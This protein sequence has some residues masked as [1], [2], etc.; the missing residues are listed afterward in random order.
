MDFLRCK[1][2]AIFLVG[3]T[4]FY[5]S[6]LLAESQE[7]LPME[8]PVLFV[9]LGSHCQIPVML[10]EYH[11]SKRAFPFDWLLTC[12]HDDFIKV[13]YDDFHFFLNENFLLSHPKVPSQLINSYYKFEFR[14]EDYPLD[15]PFRAAKKL[16]I[17]LAKPK[18]DRRI[19]RFRQIRN[20]KGKVFFLRAAS[21]NEKEAYYA[22]KADRIITSKQAAELRD[23][24][25]FFFPEVD[26]TLIIVNYLKEKAPPIHQLE[27]VLEFK[28]RSKNTFDYEG[29]AEVAEYLQNYSGHAAWQ[30]FSTSA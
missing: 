8:D 13:F 19:A 27:G 5:L 11:L 2:L 22:N 29:F 4:T 14:Y 17:E 3:C 28:V 7:D 16:Q 9:G 18:Y 12:C 30:S 24:L 20:F 26:F 1:I 23:A 25:R 15:L 10:R 6:H 21:P